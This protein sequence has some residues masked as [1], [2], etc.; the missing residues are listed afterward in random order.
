MGPQRSLPTAQ[1]KQPSQGDAMRGERAHPDLNQG[2]ADLQPFALTTGPCTHGSRRCCHLIPR[3][4]AIAAP[5]EGW[6]A[7][8]GVVGRGAGVACV[9]QERATCTARIWC[10]K[11][12]TWARHGHAGEKKPHF[13]ARMSLCGLMDK[14]PPH[15]KANVAGSSHA[16]GILA[17]LWVGVSSSSACHS[18]LLHHCRKAH[19]GD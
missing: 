5:P 11:D 1:C 6:G 13:T 16:S 3:A 4:A 19:A 14:A 18:A 7:G 15:P 17:P 2:P 10:G 12:T 8:A 9:W